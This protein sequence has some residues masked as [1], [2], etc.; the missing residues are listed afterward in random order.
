MN[1]PEASEVLMKRI[2]DKQRNIE[3]Y[4]ET[5]EPRGNRLTTFNIV[6]GAIATLLAALPAIGG[7][8]VLDLFGTPESNPDLWRVFLGAAAVFSLLSTIA[9]NMYKSREIA[10]RLAKAQAAGAKLEGLTA[11]VQAGLVEP[12]EVGT[13]YAQIIADIPF[14]TEHAVA[15]HRGHVALDEVQGTI[16]EPSPNQEVGTVIH[17]SGTVEGAGPGC[18]IWLAVE[19]DGFIWPKEREIHDDDNH[20]SFEVFE[21]GSPA[22]FSIALYAASERANKR[23]RSWL[24]R[25]D[26]TG[27]YERLRRLPDTRRLALVDGLHASHGGAK[28][29]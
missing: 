23:I 2:R 11:L 20:W 10:S 8:T 7:K 6:C 9:A 13:Q 25:G 28:A 29:E 18:H 4:I 3:R 21:Q 5:I 26:R 19:I 17:C 12:R 27:H 16:V 24:D 15:R 1:I 14:V 22:T